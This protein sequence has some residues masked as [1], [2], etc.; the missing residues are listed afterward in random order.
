MQGPSPAASAVQALDISQIRSL[1]SR[2]LAYISAHGRSSP[3]RLIGSAIGG[4]GDHGRGSDALRA[5]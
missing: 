3:A 2:R 4:F 5:C 1:R